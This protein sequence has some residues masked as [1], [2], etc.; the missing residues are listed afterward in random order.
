M[1]SVLES[2]KCDLACLPSSDPG[3]LRN[4]RRDT[5]GSRPGFLLILGGFP[6]RMV[7]VVLPPLSRQIVFCYACSQVTVLNDFGVCFCVSG[8]PESSIWC[9]KGCKQQLLTYVGV[10]LIPVSFSHIF[11]ALCLILMNFGALETGIKFDY[12]RWFSGKAGA[13]QPSPV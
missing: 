7:R 11:I 4:T 9:E 6:D 8:G 2:K 12:F 5:L 3:G 10:L 13:E 1:L